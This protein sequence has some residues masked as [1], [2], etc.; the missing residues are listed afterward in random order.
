M[1]AKTI[2]SPS[3][4]LGKNKFVD[5]GRE[6][7]FN[8]FSNPLFSSKHE[9][10]CI[11]LHPRNAEIAPLIS[12]IEKTATNLGLTLNCAQTEMSDVRG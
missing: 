9:L 5:R 3:L 4:A 1:Q 6:A 11:I 8:L 2:N 10:S 12:T 7:F